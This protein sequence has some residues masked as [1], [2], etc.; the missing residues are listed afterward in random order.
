[1][2][3]FSALNKM[4]FYFPSVRVQG[5]CLNFLLVKLV[6][7]DIGNF[8]LTDIQ[9]DQPETQFRTWA[10]FGYPAFRSQ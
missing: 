2:A 1:M 5:L 8:Q 7:F 4:A 6:V 9:D 10:G 3:S